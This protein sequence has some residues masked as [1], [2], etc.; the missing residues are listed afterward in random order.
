MFRLERL[1]ADPKL[2]QWKVPK[3]RSSICTR[4]CITMPP[5]RSVLDFMG[6]AEHGNPRC[7]RRDLRASRRHV[8][9]R[10]DDEPDSGIRPMGLLPS[11]EHQGR[12]PGSEDDSGF[13]ALTTRTRKRRRNIRR[14]RPRSNAKPN[15]KE[16]EARANFHQH[17]VFAR[18]V[19]MFQIAIA[20]AA[21][22][23]LTKKRRF[24]FVSLV[25]GAARLRLSRSGVYGALIRCVF[26]R[27]MLR[28]ATPAWR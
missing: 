23:A 7:S 10:S 11:Q 4:K 26:S 8:C 18:S 25:F 15:R 13:E 5:W 21:I 9:Q 20:I 27:S 6:G 17:E 16:A 14:N 12:D 22:S 1:L 28:S 19:T 2:G 24:W 3:F